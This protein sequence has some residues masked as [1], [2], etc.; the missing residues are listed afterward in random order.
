MSLYERTE[1]LC[2]Y[3]SVIIPGILQTPQYVRALFELACELY[4]LPE[5]EAEAAMLARMPRQKLITS[6]TGRN[7]YSFLIEA[8]ALDIVVGSSDIMKEQLN[9]LLAVT[10]LPHVSLGIIP[11]TCIRTI[12][13]GEGFYIFDGTLVRSELWSGGFRASQYEE[14]GTFVKAFARLRDMA[15]FGAAARGLIESARDHLQTGENV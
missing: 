10:A 6:G 11:T 9:F 2:A 1:L 3:E 7:R 15:V 8:G 12:Y 5:G 13:P 4:D 14:I